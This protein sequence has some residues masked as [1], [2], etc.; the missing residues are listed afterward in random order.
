MDWFYK[1]TTKT[2]IIYHANIVMGIDMEIKDRIKERLEQLRKDEK[3]TY[4]P[5][6]KFIADKAIN[7]TIEEMLNEK[8]TDRMVVEIEFQYAK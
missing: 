6:T 1:E 7:L 4:S 5:F 8:L 2:A 3:Y